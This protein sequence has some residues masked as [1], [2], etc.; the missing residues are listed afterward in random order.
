M[1]QAKKNTAA[2]SNASGTCSG[3]ILWQNVTIDENTN[4]HATIW[5]MYLYFSTFFPVKVPYQ[6][7][8]R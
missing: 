2:S 1:A 6:H 5:A 3:H 8:L 7:R 4:S